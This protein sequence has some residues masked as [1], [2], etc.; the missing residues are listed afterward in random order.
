MPS[1]LKKR[2]R[3]G[4]PRRASH[5]PCSGPSLEVPGDLPRVAWVEH[6]QCVSSPRAQ[7]LLEESRPQGPTTARL[8]ATFCPHPPRGTG[9]CP[10]PSSSGAP[11]RGREFVASGTSPPPQY[12]NCRSAKDVLP[13]FQGRLRP[14]RHSG[15]CCDS[16]AISRPPA[17]QPW[18]APGPRASLPSVGPRL[19]ATW[20]WGNGTLSREPP[21]SPAGDLA[22]LELLGSERLGPRSTLPF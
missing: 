3:A 22:R 16:R 13:V 1:D 11:R 9:P 2:C 10:A 6:G 19:P 20:G 15:W 7:E 17:T 12:S 4:C 8:W 18:V 21:S 14:G 5:C